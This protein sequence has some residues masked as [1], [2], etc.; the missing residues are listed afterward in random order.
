MT[1]FSVVAVEEELQVGVKAIGCKAKDGKIGQ[2]SRI[3]RVREQQLSHAE[4]GEQTQLMTL[5]N[6]ATEITNQKRN[7]K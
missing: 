3:G 1:D 5:T 7:S 2:L 4:R 6:H